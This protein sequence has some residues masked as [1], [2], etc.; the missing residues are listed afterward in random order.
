MSIAGS[1]SEAM[2]GKNQ[3]IPE[4]VGLKE[5]PV[6]FHSGQL[7]KSKGN[8]PLRVFQ[9]FILQF[10]SQVSKIMFQNYY[11]ATLKIKYK[12]SKSNGEKWRTLVKNIVLMQNPHS[13]NNGNIC[14][15]VND[16]EF[17]TYPVRPSIYALRFIYKQP[18]PHWLRFRIDNLSLYTITKVNLQAPESPKTIHRAANVMEQ[19]MKVVWN[20]KIP[21]LNEQNVS[22][23]LVSSLLNRIVETDYKIKQ[24]VG[25]L[26]KGLLHRKSSSDI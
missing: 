6:K 22:T 3:G 18:S 23:C 26:H 10:P 2:E 19:N 11:T 14:V 1:F 15:T 5:E 8:P 7:C 17:T 25:L 16:K 24:G 21:Y 9:D 13:E 12:T 4:G 20:Q